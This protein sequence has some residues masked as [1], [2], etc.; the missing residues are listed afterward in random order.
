[1]IMEGLI[2]IGILLHIFTSGQFGIDVGD[3]VVGLAT[4]ILGHATYTLAFIEREESLIDRDH[5]E[6]RARIY[7]IAHVLLICKT[8]FGC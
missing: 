6:A 8:S 2:G 3:G 7:L 5:S 1:M 4:M